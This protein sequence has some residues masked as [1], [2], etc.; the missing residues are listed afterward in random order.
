MVNTC[1]CCG[2]T[3]PEGTQLCY[4]CE[5]NV[6]L[7]CPNCGSALRLMS[8]CKASSREQILY[9]RL[10][11]CDTCNTDWETNTSADDFTGR[12]KRKFFG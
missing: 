7:S 9:Y 2:D 4:C 3:I 11:S 10:Y 12:L 8:S 1:V 6:K 5:N